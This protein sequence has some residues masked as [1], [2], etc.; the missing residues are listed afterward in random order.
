M[1]EKRKLGVIGGLGPAATA[2]LFSKVV[3]DTDAATD[4]D[5]LDVTVLNR[6]GIPDRTSY[7]LGESDRDFAPELVRAARDLVGLGCEVVCIACVTAH[8]ALPQVRDAVGG[9][10]HVIDLPAEMAADLVGAGCS[11]VGLLATDGT[12]RTGL[13]QGAFSEA[14]LEC[15]VPDAEFQRL[16]MRTIYDEVKAGAPADMGNVDRV[17]AHLARKGCDGLA[18]GCTELPLLGLPERLRGMRVASSLDILARCAVLA[19]GGALRQGA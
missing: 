10:A 15:A 18:L 12:L 19:C 16:V 7:L 4:Q 3:E 8:A 1:Q 13:L 11:R 6:P 9:R 14:G 17:C 5:H 2:Y